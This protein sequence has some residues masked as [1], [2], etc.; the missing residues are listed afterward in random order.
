MGRRQVNVVIMRT[1]ASLLVI[2]CLLAVV[3]VFAV[4]NPPPAQHCS[5]IGPRVD[6]GMCVG[7]HAHD[8][9]ALS[10]SILFSYNVEEVAKKLLLAAL[11]TLMC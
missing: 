11:H 4:A 6:C 2:P 1:G 8:V 10:E 3:R 9:K 7:S 5:A